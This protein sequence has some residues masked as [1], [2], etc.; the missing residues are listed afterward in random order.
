MVIICLLI[1]LREPKTQYVICRGNEKDL[2]FYEFYNHRTTNYRTPGGIYTSHLYSD[3]G[4]PT[5]CQAMH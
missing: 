4:V 5:M 1:L 3:F 2:L